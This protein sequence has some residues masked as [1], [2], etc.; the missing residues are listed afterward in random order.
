MFLILHDVFAPLNCFLRF[1]PFF[2]NSVN[3]SGDNRKYRESVD[4]SK[5]GVWC[6][7]NRRYLWI[8][9]VHVLQVRDTRDYVPGPQGQLATNRRSMNDG[10][11]ERGANT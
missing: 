6:W 4:V 11:R 8:A 1:L 2:V 9:G 3:L 10:L 5:A 7:I